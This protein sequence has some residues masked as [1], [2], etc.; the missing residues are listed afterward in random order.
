MR[1]TVPL[2]LSRRSL[3]L[4]IDMKSYYLGIDLGTSSVKGILRS[5]DG[6][7]VKGRSSYSEK[8]VAGWKAAIRTMLAEMLDELKERGGTVA[9][10]S[11]S[12]QVGTYVIDGEYVVGWQS[13]A[14]REELAEIKSMISEEEFIDAIGMPHPD[15]IS[16]PLPRL[17]YI[18]RNYP[19][20]REVLMPKEH[21]IR[22][23]TGETVTDVFSMRGIVHPKT[24]HYATELMARLGITLRL[25]PV[26]RPTD[27]AGRV[28]AEASAV[29]GLPEGIPVYLGCNDFFAGLLGMG[30][31]GTNTAFDLSGTS[32][33]IGFISESFVPCGMVSGGYFNGFCTY[34]GTKSSGVSCAFAMKHFDLGEIS[35][36]EELLSE[37]PPLFLPYLNGERAPIFDENARGVYFG[38]REET[39]KKHM[40]YAT[41]E[42]VTF[43]LWDIA[44]HLG[45]P[46]PDRLICGGGSAVD[47]VMNALRAQ[48]FSCEVLCVKENDTSA[49]GA[50]MLAAVGAGFYQT[51]PEAIEGCVSY[52]EP[53]KPHGAYRDVLKARFAVYQRLYRDLKETFVL[54]NE[55][56]KL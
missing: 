45:M 40:A 33:H 9:A 27:L 29:Y 3:P 20:A 49:L 22:E 10:V 32:E 51:L 11:F 39:E 14:G 13:S 37:R 35:S 24:G 23:W 18:Q 31:Y 56:E 5:A 52:H 8:T 53:I 41:L 54:F 15:I 43:S 46:H 28:S 16:Y 17:L 30:V 38:I 36:V 47:P 12:S 1:A 25:P 7:T 55:G 6:D 26:K 19:N 34:G 21:L 50:M 42:G 4:T 2:A 48:L 44:E